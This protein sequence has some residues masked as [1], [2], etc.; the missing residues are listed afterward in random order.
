VGSRRQGLSPVGETGKG[1]R[2]NKNGKMYLT[3]FIYNAN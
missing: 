2:I 1:V 3:T